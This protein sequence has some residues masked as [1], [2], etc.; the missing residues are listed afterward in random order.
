MSIS[1]PQYLQEALSDEDRNRDEDYA[2]L[3]GLATV[4]LDKKLESLRDLV[5]PQVAGPTVSGEPGWGIERQHRKGEVLQAQLRIRNHF[6]RAGLDAD[7]KPLP[8]LSAAQQ[9]EHARTRERASRSPVMNAP[10]PSEDRG[11]DPSWPAWARF[12]VDLIASEFGD[13]KYPL[14][15]YDAAS[16][17]GF[18]RKLLPVY[19]K[20]HPESAELVDQILAH[21]HYWVEHDATHVLGEG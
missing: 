6:L 19:V 18:L 16:F 3:Y 8:N 5:D 10:L 4:F 21:A 1:H 15:Y 9:E 17:E 2:L 13:P 14:Q 11:A 7:G 12:K 20:Y